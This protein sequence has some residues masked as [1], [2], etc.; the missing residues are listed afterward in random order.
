MD[1]I[2]PERRS[3]LRSR[4][5]SKDTGIEVTVRK[6]LHRLGFRYRLGGARL[7]G[8]PDIVLPKYRVVI[9]VH[10]CFWHGH[11]CPLYRPPKTRRAF[12]QSKIESNR[13]RDARNYAKL[14]LMAWRVEIIWECQLRKMPEREVKQTIEAL[15]E[16]IQRG[17]HFVRQR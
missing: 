15:A 9:F 13:E 1:I 17:I 12:W 7:P 3:A 8:R 10:G 4:I 14:H 6:A 5:R 11:D 2:S 16:R